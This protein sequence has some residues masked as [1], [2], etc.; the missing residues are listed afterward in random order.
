LR[1]RF[2]KKLFH[3][4][5]LPVHFCGFGDSPFQSN[6]RDFYLSLF[7]NILSGAS[8]QRIIDPFVCFFK[9]YAVVVRCRWVN[10]FPEFLYFFTGKYDI[11][12]DKARKHMV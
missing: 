8:A 3:V 7:W 12:G 11:S 5:D 1:K 4:F 9:R 10:D 2:F 6:F